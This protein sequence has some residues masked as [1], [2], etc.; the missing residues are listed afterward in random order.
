MG[1]YVYYC[2][3]CYQIYVNFGT[4]SCAKFP[5]F[6]IWLPS[7]IASHLYL[8]AVTGKLFRLIGAVEE[9]SLKQLYGHH[10]E[11]EHEQHVDNEDVQH[12]LQRVHYTVKDS[13]KIDKREETNSNAAWKQNTNS[14][15]KPTHLQIVKIQNYKDP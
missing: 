7:F 12:I 8:P 14:K 15:H 1:E 3:P 5:F 13:L 10:S 4:L 2:G 9:S 6:D 11:D